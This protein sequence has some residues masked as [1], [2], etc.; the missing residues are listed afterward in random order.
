MKYKNFGL[1]SAQVQD[2]LSKNGDNSLT[3]PPKETFVHK[4]WL[5]FQDPIIKILIF[6]LLINVFFVY[7]GHGDWI[8]TAGIFLAIILATFVSTYSEY[9]N[10]SAFKKLQ[11]EASLINCKV[12]RNGRPQEIHIDDIVV[13]DEVILQAGDKVPADGIL[14]D[15]EIKVDQAA[16]N[17]ESEEAC[18]QIAPEDFIWGTGNI[19]FLE[20][21]KLFRGS[22]VVEG[23]GIMRALAIGDNSI[24]GKLTQELKDDDRDSPLKVKLTKLAGQISKAGYTV[25]L[26]IVLVVMLNNIFSAVSV[27]A[28][29]SNISQVVQD[30]VQ[31]AILGIIIIVM[32]VPEGLPLMIAI[33]SSLNMRKMLRDSVLVRKLAGIETAGSLNLLYT[34]KTGTITKGKLEVVDFLIGNGTTYQDFSTLPDK[35][36]KLTFANC[37]LNTSAVVSE[38]K[39]IGGNMT[40]VALS[41]YLSGYSVDLKLEKIRFIPFNSTN[42]YSWAHLKSDKDFCLIKGAPDK[43][44]NYADHYFDAKGDLC[45]LTAEEK[46]LLDRKMV[47]FAKASIRMLGLF[48]YEGTIAGDTLPEEGL[49]LIGIACIRDDVRPEAVAAIKE[50]QNAGVQVVMITGDRKETAMAIAIDAGIICAATDVV[51]TSEELAVL[52]DEEIKKYIPNLRVVARA[53]P[54]DKSRLVRLSQEMGLVVGMTGDG[55]NDSPALKKA[56]VGFAMGSG[57]EVAKEAGDI[58]ILDDN[59]LSIKKAILYGRTIYNSICKFIT[60]QLTINFSAVAINLIAPFIGIVRPLTITQILWI[61]LIMDTMAAIAFGGEPALTEY[62]KEKPKNRQAPIVSRDMSISI[63]LAGA[64]M[65]FIGLLFFKSATVDHWFRNAPDHIYTYTGF[66]CVYVFMAVFNAFNVRVNSMNLLKNINRN[67]GFL[68]IMALIVIVQLML[69]FVGG[70]VLRMTPLTKVEWIIVVAMSFSMVIVDLMRKFVFK[71]LEKG[72]KDIV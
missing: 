13:G 68:Q 60:F 58:V 37:L 55:V 42:K 50:V 24:Y 39:V 69:T 4:L 70:K 11:E 54:M 26:L 25:G 38:G 61:N 65:T 23:Q 22:V 67:V 7:T 53:L 48:S 20:V 66:F 63:V 56:D 49:I 10:E 32:A 6:A 30:L 18:K 40:E 47:V 57:T 3:Q 15:G 43:L 52:S 51:W 27:A 21:H 17:G 19:D 62:L 72:R 1:T 31:A 8:E 34:D 2:S 46:L 5:N 14:L 41:N 29:F 9:N 16:L 64:Y 71:K 45:V 35:I 59:F 12:W 36:K 33:V 44:I 28:Y